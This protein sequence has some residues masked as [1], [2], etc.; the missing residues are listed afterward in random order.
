M[1]RLGHSHY[2]QVYRSSEVPLSPG[3]SLVRRLL[4]NASLKAN[5]PKV[6]ASVM[7]GSGS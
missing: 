5:W 7:Q 1:S 4:G 6:G 2:A 3:I